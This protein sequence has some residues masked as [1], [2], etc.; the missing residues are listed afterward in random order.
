M[1]YLLGLVGLSAFELPRGF[2]QFSELES[3]QAKAYEEEE[4]VIFLISDSNLRPT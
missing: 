4:P 2:H 1:A 3:A